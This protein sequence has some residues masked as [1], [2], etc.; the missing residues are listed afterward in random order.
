MEE[1][2]RMKN[3][4]KAMTFT[5]EDDMY[6]LAVQFEKGVAI[7][8]MDT[9][10][11]CGRTLI[12]GMGVIYQEWEHDFVG[13]PYVDIRKLLLKT[14]VNVFR[15]LQEQAQYKADDMLKTFEAD[16]FNIE[17]NSK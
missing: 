2:D 3:L 10:L 13:V 11:L 16:A 1:G 5:K 7:T 15:E 12:S 17:D 8:T 9:T 6:R 14:T 4:V